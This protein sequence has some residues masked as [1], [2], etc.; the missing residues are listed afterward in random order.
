MPEHGD[1]VV[2]RD[3]AGESAVFVHNGERDEVVLVEQRGDFVLGRIRGAGDVRFAQVREL[4]GRR[5]DRDLDERHRPRQLLGGTGQ[6]DGGERFVAAFERLQGLDRVV[7]HATFRHRDEVGRHA[8]GGGVL[9]EFEELG[10]LPPLRRLHFL[11]NL[12]R[13]F[14]AQTAE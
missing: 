4:D 6:I 13:L 1:H 5:R 10:D 11:E 3:D 9:A 7:H 2:G 12:A 14:L 8:A